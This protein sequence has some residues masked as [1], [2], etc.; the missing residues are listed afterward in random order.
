VRLGI[1]TGLV[2]VGEMGGGTHE[3]LALGETSNLTARLQG[4]AAPNTLVLSAATVPLLGGFFAYQSLGPH[5][6]KGLPQ[7]IEVCQVLSESIARSRLEVAGGTGLTPPLRGR[8]FES[9]SSTHG[10]TAL[11]T[12]YRGFPY[13]PGRQGGRRCL[14]R[15]VL[16]NGPL[17]S[18]PIDP[19]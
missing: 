13:T 9:G 17:G 16:T 19:S 18:A 4:I 6:L 3:Q 5:L 14:A 12:R 8:F 15:P 11:L 7:P 1:H 10:K 2:V